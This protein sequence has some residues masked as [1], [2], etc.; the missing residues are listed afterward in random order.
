MSGENNFSPI[1]NQVFDGRDGSSNPS[2]ISNV[3][4]IIKWDIQIS[5]DEDFLALQIGRAKVSNA[6]LGHG[7]NG[8]NRVGGGLE[9]SELGCDVA[10]EERISDSAGETEAAERSFEEEACR[11]RG[12]RPVGGRG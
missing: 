5:P 12:G 9:R 11:G 1:G 3:L 10:G 6:L 4:C 2:V 7:D 8:P